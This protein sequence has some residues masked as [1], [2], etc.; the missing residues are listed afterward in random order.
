MLTGVLLVDLLLLSPFSTL[1]YYCGL[2]GVLHALL[3]VLLWLEWRFRPSWHVPLIAVLALIKTFV[4]INSGAALLSDT[5]W[6]P[7]AWSHV[8]GLLGGAILV[9]CH[10]KIA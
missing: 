10:R 8:A 2:S 3:V 5:S 6:P 9:G 1:N 7:Y 4:E